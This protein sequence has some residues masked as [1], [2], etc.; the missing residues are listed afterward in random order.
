VTVQAGGAVIDTNGYNVAI[1]NNLASGAS[2]DGGLTKKGAGT[3][4]LTGANAYNGGTKIKGGILS[5]SSDGNLGAVIGTLLI[6]KDPSE[7]QAILKTTA[8][9]TLDPSRPFS[10][11]PGGGTIDTDPSTLTLA[12]YA[13]TAVSISGPL[14]VQGGGVLTIDLASTPTLTSEAAMTIAEST[15]LN[16]GGTADP[17]SDGAVHM[18]VVNYGDL[19]ITSGT[20]QV[21]ALS[22]STGITTLSGS[23][24]LIATSIVQDT[25]NIG[26]DPGTTF[27]AID[28]GATSGS[29]LTQVPE[30]ATWAMLMLAA[31]GLGI[32]R[33]RRR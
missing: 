14:T 21:G 29:S 31:M 23:S 11:G 6:D 3:L 22:G 9:F 2:P 26:T 33:R 7:T 5:V 16:A 17:F 20:K 28:G 19:N 4:T 32:Y 8:S 30:P 13:A 12:P 1:N 10:I 18:N 25:L 27:A 24:Q 15:T